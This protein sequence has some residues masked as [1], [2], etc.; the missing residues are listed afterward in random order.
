MTGMDV[1]SHGEVLSDTGKFVAVYHIAAQPIFG[2]NPCH[3]NTCSH[4]CVLSVK[5]PGHFK[6]LP[7]MCQDIP[8]R[9][10]VI[11]CHRS[12]N[13]LLDDNLRFRISSE[14]DYLVVAYDNILAFTLAGNL[15]NL[16]NSIR[17][18][19]EQ[20][21][22]VNTI[23]S[24]DYNPLRNTIILTDSQKVYEYDPTSKALDELV[25]PV[26]HKVL[27]LGIDE[28]GENL[29]WISDNGTV[30]VM[31]LRSRY[32][33]VLVSDLENPCEIL[34]LPNHG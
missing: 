6:C 8:V 21:S 27:S 1:K 32:Q 2:A 12:D 29:Y 28:V 25:E 34:M 13:C 3:R 30:T 19:R 5:S 22:E 33:L 10:G 23:T 26:P 16:H 11:S 24:L 9:T 17:F 15:K 20:I 7:P 4:M 31:S 18:E 14:S